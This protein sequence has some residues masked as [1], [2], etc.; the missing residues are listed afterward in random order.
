PELRRFSY[1]QLAAATN[2]FDQGNVIGSSNLSTV[3]KGVL[4][5]D[6]DGGMVVAVKR[7]NLEQFPSKSDK[8]FLTELATLSRLRH[9]NLARVVGYAW[10]AGKI[11]AL[12]LDY[13]VNGDLDGAIH[14][15]AAAPPPAPSRWT[16]RERLRVCVSVAHGLVYL[17]SGYDF[18]VVHCAVKPSN[19][20]LDGDWEARVSDFGTA[21]ML[22][23]HL[24][25]AAN[26]AAQS[27]ATSSAFRGTVGYMAP[28][29]AYMRTV[30][31]KVDV[32]SF[33]VLAM[34]LFTGRRPTGTIE[35]DGVPLTL[36]QLVDNAV[37]RG[38]D[39]VHAVLDPRMKVATEAD[40]STAADVLAVALSCAAFEP[41]DRPD[42][43]AVLSSLLKMS[44]L[45]GEDSK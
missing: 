20:L 43:G 35:E 29:F 41:A 34:E 24:P 7:L 26:A 40:L 6:A 21:R 2:S 28:E 36:Q 27:T 3:Y 5:G 44:K 11:K 22:G 38:L 10:E 19:V 14:G 33:G 30:S 39:G 17:H 9:K 37:S 25:A 15:G 1:G 8:C 23:V 16:V 32:F 45:V 4:A 31:T 42:M 18:P 12:V 13:M